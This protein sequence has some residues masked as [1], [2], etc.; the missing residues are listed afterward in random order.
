[1]YYVISFFNIL[2]V[3]EYN[4]SGCIHLYSNDLMICWYSHVFELWTDSCFCLPLTH[5]NSPALHI[6]HINMRVELNCTID[7]SQ[8]L[9][10]MKHRGFVKPDILTRILSGILDSSLNQDQGGS[11]SCFNCRGV[12]LFSHIHPLSEKNHIYWW[13]VCHHASLLLPTHVRI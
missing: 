5:A 7:Y 11:G 8:E 12:L 4:K 2:F 6:K 10:T 9:D 13:V 1:M 3:Y